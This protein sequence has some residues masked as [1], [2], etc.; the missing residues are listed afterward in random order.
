[1]GELTP[2]ECFLAGVSVTSTGLAL[3]LFFA[4][5]SLGKRIKA[6]QNKRVSGAVTDLADGVRPKD[7]TTLAA[8]LRLQEIEKRLSALENQAR[9]VVP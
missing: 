9:Q 1:M 3:L 4:L 2:L 7:R 8:E 6:E 5:I